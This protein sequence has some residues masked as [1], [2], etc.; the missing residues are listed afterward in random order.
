MVEVEGRS[1]QSLVEQGP[2]PLEHNILLYLLLEVVVLAV[3][4][5]MD[6]TL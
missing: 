3:G 1:F 4:L 2:F 5:P 6:T